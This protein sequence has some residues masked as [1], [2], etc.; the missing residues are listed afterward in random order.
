MSRDGGLSPRQESILRVI[1]NSTTECGEGPTVRQ[2]GERVSLS[3]ISSV[4][5]RLGR[6]EALGRTAAP[7]AAGVP[8][9]SAPGRASTSGST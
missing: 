5:Y 6:L 7:L 2:I 8:A 3:S 9:G 4:A 1:R